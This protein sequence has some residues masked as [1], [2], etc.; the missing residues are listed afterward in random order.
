VNNIANR[1]SAVFYLA[2][3]E[4]YRGAQDISQVLQAAVDRGRDVSAKEIVVINADLLNFRFACFPLPYRPSDPH[5]LP[6][7]PLPS[8]WLN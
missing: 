4:R 2:L 1:S 7:A 8:R 3:N 5:F 6:P